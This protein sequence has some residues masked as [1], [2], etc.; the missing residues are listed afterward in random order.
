MSEDNYNNQAYVVRLR[1]LPWSCTNED[2]KN[3]LNVPI[4]N[5]DDGIHL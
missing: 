1:G 2:I 3:F 5:G 4:K